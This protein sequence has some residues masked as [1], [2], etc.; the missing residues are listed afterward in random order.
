MRLL[1]AGQGL[2]FVDAG[3][4]QLGIALEPQFQHKGYG[5]QL[6]LETLAAAARAGY[7]QVSLTVHPDNP[8][9]YLY[10]ACGFRRIGLRGT[11]LLMLVA[12]AGGAGPPAS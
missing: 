11:Y 7:T 10:E 3:T 12:L 9:Q 6:M 2:A 1:P 5:R 8:A 4:P